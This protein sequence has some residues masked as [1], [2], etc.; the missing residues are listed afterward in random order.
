MK[1]YKYQNTKSMSKVWE[2]FKELGTM[3]TEQLE[4]LYEGSN[5][6]HTLDIVNAALNGSISLTDESVSGFN[7]AA[8]EYRCKE[9]DKISNFNRCKDIVNIIDVDNSDDDLKVGYGEVSSRAIKSFEDSYDEVINSEEFE[10]NIRMLYGIR[11]KYIIEHGI[12]LVSVLRSSLQGI[13]EAINEV[14]NLMSDN[15]VKDL[16]L[17]LCENSSDGR[18]LKALEATA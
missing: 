17:S 12:D 1:Y 16:I 9:T 7:L 18:L 6:S 13:P 8:Y 4:K 5:Y 10:E 15:C 3:S 11:S 2:L 14:K